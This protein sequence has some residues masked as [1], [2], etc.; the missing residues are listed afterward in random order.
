GL[1]SLT[2]S[3]SAGGVAGE[4]ILSIRNVGSGAG[5]IGFDGTN[6]RYAGTLIG[7]ASGGSSGN[8]LA[9]AWYSQA[10]LAAASALLAAIT[11]QNTSATPNTSP[12]TV[13]FVAVD[14]DGV[15]NGGADS[16][17]ATTTIQIAGGG[18]GTTTTIS[19]QDGLFPTS[20]YNLTRD[21][22]IRSD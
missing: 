14:G 6:V 12:R 10:T 18:G 17:T 9:V 5:Q 19:F 16:T 1:G 15:A 7:T 8:P 2:V 20:S 11:Y 13:S 3:F 22:K 21:T 4:D